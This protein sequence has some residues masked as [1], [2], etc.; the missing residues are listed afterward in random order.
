[1]QASCTSCHANAFAATHAARYT[2]D[3]RET[4]VTCH[5]ASGQKAADKAH[6]LP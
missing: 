6:G 5:G 1:M 4:C 3:G 2:V